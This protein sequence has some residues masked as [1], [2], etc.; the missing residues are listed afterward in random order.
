MHYN[1]EQRKLIDNTLAKVKESLLVECYAAGVDLYEMGDRILNEHIEMCTANNCTTNYEISRQFGFTSS[2]VIGEM[3]LPKLLNLPLKFN[4][5]LKSN[6]Y[7]YD[8]EINGL[9]L[10][11]KNF[12]EFR[13]V[14]GEVPVNSLKESR[15][16]ANREITDDEYKKL[17]LK[18]ESKKRQESWEQM[19]ILKRGTINNVEVIMLHGLVLK[20]DYDLHAKVIKTKTN[21]GYVCINQDFVITDI[22]SIQSILNKRTGINNPIKKI[23]F[24]LVYNIDNS[25]TEIKD[26]DK[27]LEKYMNR[28]KIVDLADTLFNDADTQ[29][30]IKKSG[31]NPDLIKDYIVKSFELA[32]DKLE[33]AT[34]LENFFRAHKQLVNTNIIYNFII[35][36]HPNYDPSKPETTLIR[37]FEYD[38]MNQKNQLWLP[39]DLDHYLYYLMDPTIFVTPTWGS[40]ESYAH[41]NALSPITSGLEKYQMKELANYKSALIFT[42][43]NSEL[44]LYKQVNNIDKIIKTEEGLK[45]G[46]TIMPLS[47]GVLKGHIGVKLE[48]ATDPS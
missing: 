41:S 45:K 1:I 9:F 26:F 23:P 21:R 43:K 20:K 8:A 42:V 5:N 31:K 18:L 28:N 27:H 14:D 12:A 46:R 39:L 33:Q 29:V 25:R 15:Q 10:E 11:I 19:I 37:Y 38:L 30:I 4:K 36:Q 34:N 44:I 3:L 24:E 17:C 48:Y 16:Y 32:A 47:S 35:K 13:F 22:T 40:T 2:G 7:Y 6:G